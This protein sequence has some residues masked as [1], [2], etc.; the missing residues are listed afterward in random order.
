MVDSTFQSY[1]ATARGYVYF[2]FDRPD[3]PDRTLVKA[4]QVALDVY[5]QAPSATKQVIVGQRD[6]KLLPTD[7]R[8]HLDHLTVVQDDFGDAM[9][10]GDGD[11][12]EAVVHP[13]A[14]G[15][16]SVYDFQLG[17]TRTHRYAGGT[18][19]IPV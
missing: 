17:D 15:S 4:D 1:H 8:Y 3:R 2:F 5:W 19:E 7:I 9:R 6:E 13:V 18:P 12:V 16:Q 14:P 11:E 10:M